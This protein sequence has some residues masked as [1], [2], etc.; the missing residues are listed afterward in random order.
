[1]R[2]AEHDSTYQDSQPVL[3]GE[4]AASASPVSLALSQVDELAADDEDE[5]MA[6]PPPLNLVKP[7]R[8]AD[9][10]DPDISRVTDSQAMPDYSS[11]Q[12][13]TMH[14]YG[15][16]DDQFEPEYPEAELGDAVDSVD[17]ELHPLVPPR[18]AVFAPFLPPVAPDAA[19]SSPI[20]AFSSPPQPRPGAED[21][22]SIS[23]EPSQQILLGSSSSPVLQPSEMEGDLQDDVFAEAAFEPVRLISIDALHLM[24]I[25]DVYRLN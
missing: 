24:N 10:V 11:L 1:M 8:K 18:P 3:S 13:T 14:E 2:A 12:D 4:L 17:T 23:I 6:L 9:E 15:Q 25:V 16:L 7:R 21:L 19:P 5:D 22:R 20:Q